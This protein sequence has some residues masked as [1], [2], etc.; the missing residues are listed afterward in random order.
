MKEE[1]KNDSVWLFLVDFYEWEE[2]KG[3]EGKGRLAWLFFISRVN[4]YMAKITLP[5]SLSHSCIRRL[6]MEN[7]ILFFWVAGE[8]NRPIS[9]SLSLSLPCRQDLERFLIYLRCFLLCM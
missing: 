8:A 2:R 7:W 6:I 5:L 3:R 4:H 9:L 1:K